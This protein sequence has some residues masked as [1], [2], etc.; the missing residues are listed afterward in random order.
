M[1]AGH[2]LV[3]HQHMRD[4]VRRY[5]VSPLL[6]ALL[7]LG[8]WWLFTADKSDEGMGGL[9]LSILIAAFGPIATWILSYHVLKW[10][11]VERPGT[12]AGWGVCISTGLAF[13]VVQ[14]QPMHGWWLVVIGVVAFFL[15]AIF[16]GGADRSTTDALRR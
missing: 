11:R 5:T 4:S 2:P 15:G 10:A 7:G 12:T 9:G 3:E 13:I 16:A 6:G 1:F 8:F 14:R